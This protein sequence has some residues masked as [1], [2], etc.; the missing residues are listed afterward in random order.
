MDRSKFARSD[1]FI[2]VTPESNFG[3][4]AV[5]KNRLDCVYPE[6]NG[7]PVALLGYGG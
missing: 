2:I 1:G 5:L 4:P 6:W 3:P 7:R